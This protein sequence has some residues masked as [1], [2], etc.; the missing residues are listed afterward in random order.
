MDEYNDKY[1][2]FED[3]S[4][5]AESEKAIKVVGPEIGSEANNVWIPKSQIHEDSE[6]YANATDGDLIISLWIAKEK[7]LT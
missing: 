7:G 4:C 2:K 6:V 3:C 1:V 5:V